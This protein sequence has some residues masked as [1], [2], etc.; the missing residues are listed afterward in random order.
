MRVLFIAALALCLGGC[1]R[2]SSSLLRQGQLSVFDFPLYMSDG[3]QGVIYRF[4]SNRKHKKIVEGLED[5]RGVAT[6][7]FGNLYVAEY[8]AGRVLKVDP[9]TGKYTVIRE[10]LG[11]PSVLAT[12]SMG[13]VFIGEDDSRTVVRVSDAKEF[14]SPG[15]LVSAMIFGVA[16][17]LIIGTF[18]DNKLRWTKGSSVTVASPVA[19]A[20]DGSGRVFAASGDAEAG[21]VYRFHQDS[22]GKGTMVADGLQGPV[23]MAV[24]PVGNLDVVEQA[25]QRVV[26]ITTDLHKY[27][28]MHQSEAGFVDPQYLA[29]TQY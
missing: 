7:R 9:D 11:H 18:G 2:S 1:G 27:S 20:I 17:R 26:L 6:D 4:E 13:E 5:P 19:A 3:T 21:K 16:D 24:D 15:D 10:G 12:N 29:F 23:G 25:A 22:P 28:W 14:A 8:G